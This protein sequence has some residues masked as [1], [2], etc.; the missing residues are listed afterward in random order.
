MTPRR[1]ARANPQPVSME[2]RFTKM[3]GL[4]N[5]FGVIDTV[6]QSVDL[7]PEQVRFLADRRFG[8]GCDQVLLVESARNPECGVSI[9]A[10]YRDQFDAAI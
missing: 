1:K 2:L 6:R 8:I 10:R 7:K 4:G 9:V 5:D 3:H